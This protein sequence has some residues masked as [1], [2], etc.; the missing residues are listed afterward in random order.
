M[1]SH[2]LLLIVKNPP[3]FVQLGF[4]DFSL[5]RRWWKLCDV[6]F[7]ETRKPGFINKK[8]GI[9]Y[10]HVAIGGRNGE[11]SQGP[12]FRQISILNSL[13]TYE[14]N[15][16]IH[17]YRRQTSLYRLFRLLLY[18]FNCSIFF[19]NLKKIKGK[20]SSHSPSFIFALLLLF[21][22]LRL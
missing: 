1:P 21:L 20:R 6:F 3:R 10:R 8:W 16:F 11:R 14:D 15:N 7:P 19:R 12:I 17:L 9:L 18:N 2:K 22:V 5:Y 13:A 4:I